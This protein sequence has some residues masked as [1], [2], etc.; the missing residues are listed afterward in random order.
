M[1]LSAQAP[2][3]PV[4]HDLFDAM[5]IPLMPLLTQ[6]SDDLRYDAE[7]IRQAIEMAAVAD[8]FDPSRLTAEQIEAAAVQAGLNADTVREGLR[9]ARRMRAWRELRRERRGEFAGFLVGLGLAVSW[10]LIAWFRLREAEWTWFG[11]NSFSTLIFPVLLALIQGFAAKRPSSAFLLGMLL[12]VGV[13]PTFWAWVLRSSNY[14]EIREP[15]PLAMG[16]ACAYAAL[17]GP[18]LGMLGIVGSKLR[19][20]YFPS[21]QDA[22][23]LLAT[24]SGRQHAD[25]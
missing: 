6:L 12:A 2:A 11:G 1:Q 17:A 21:Q 19:S 5:G 14:N 18:A 23:R 24:A 22:D 20:Y 3:M 16:A 25:Y 8:R 10:S 7:E 13:A 9:Q 4:Q 15:I